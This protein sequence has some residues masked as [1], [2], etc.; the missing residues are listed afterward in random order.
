MSLMLIILLGPYLILTLTSPGRC[1]VIT[2]QGGGET[3][4]TAARAESTV[5]STGSPEA[6]LLAAVSRNAS[7]LEV[8][9]LLQ[10]GANPDAAF[11]DRCA[12]LT[13]TRTLTRDRCPGPNP[14][15]DPDLDPDPN[16]DPGP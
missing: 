7:A 3:L 11:L 15:P 2:C 5:T 10:R 1:V 12:T 16:P 8:R 9:A 4:E 13:R 14:N 6:A